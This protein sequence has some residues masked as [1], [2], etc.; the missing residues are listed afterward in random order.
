MAT[1]AET[2][3]FL[4][5]PLVTKERKGPNM[6]SSATACIT[7]LAPAS[8]SRSSGLNIPNNYLY[9]STYELYKK[10]T[11]QFLHKKVS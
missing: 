11:M 9:Y 5:V 10:N 4:T 2:G 7:R 3:L 1:T 8:I 6:V